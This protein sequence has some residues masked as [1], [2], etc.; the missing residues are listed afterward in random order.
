MYYRYCEDSLLIG[1]D[2]RSSIGLLFLSAIFAYLLVHGVLHESK[3]CALRLESYT[4]MGILL[5]GSDFRHSSLDVRLTLIPTINTFQYV[6]RYLIIWDAIY[7]DVLGKA[8]GTSICKQR[9]RTKVFPP[10]IYGLIQG[11]HIG[12]LAP[13]VSF[14]S[15]QLSLYLEFSI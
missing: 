7:F 8:Y 13:Y 12:L 11:L 10:P 14:Q 1:G 6:H 4:Y 2:Y 9:K 15:Q 3:S 5:D